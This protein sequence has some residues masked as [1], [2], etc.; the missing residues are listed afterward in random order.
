MKVKM[1][2]D[3]W[4]ESK[5]EDDDQEIVCVNPISS[6]VFEKFSPMDETESVEDS[7]GLLVCACG[8]LFCAC[9]DSCACI[10]F[11]GECAW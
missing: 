4:R 5:G 9:G 7:C 10:P 1:E 8:F 11:V 6:D 3:M 2:R